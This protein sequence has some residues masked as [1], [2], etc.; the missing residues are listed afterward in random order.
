VSSGETQAAEIVS[1]V[2]DGSG[3]L[4]WYMSRFGHDTD[5]QALRRSDRDVTGA[6][7]SPAPGDAFIR[8]VL[9]GA[10]DGRDAVYLLS[11]ASSTD[12]CTPASPCAV[13]PACSEAAPCELRR[14]SGLSFVRR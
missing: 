11:G 7:I 14:A 12:P 2:S 10:F 8:A 1:P 6:R 5:S 3:R 9:A 4:R 13:E